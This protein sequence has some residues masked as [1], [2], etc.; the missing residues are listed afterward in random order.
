MF[1]LYETATLTVNSGTSI[2]SSTASDGGAVLYAYSMTDSNSIIINMD[3]VTID[4]AASST[5]G[6][7]FFLSS[8]GVSLTANTIT[9]KSIT[10]TGNGGVILMVASGTV[11]IG[12]NSKFTDIVAS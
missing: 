8:T 10:S 3:T 7:V 11:S 9:V 1:Y 2:T 6:G 4:T 12:S 5:H